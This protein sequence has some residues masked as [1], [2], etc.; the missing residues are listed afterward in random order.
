M[1]D[2]KI[3]NN[4]TTFNLRLIFW[5]TNILFFFKIFF[6]IKN[7]SPQSFLYVVSFFQDTFLVITVY[8]I[9]EFF[10]TKFS[11]I[12]KIITIFFYILLTLITL[13]SFLY[14][15]FITDLLNFP[16]NI[17]AIQTENI[18][19]FL[20]YFL[21]FSLIL[22]VIAL[23]ALIVFLSI[24][25]PKNIN[26]KILLVFSILV[27]VVFLITIPRP[28]IN[29][30][31]YSVTDEIKTIF[32]KSYGIKRLQN[33]QTGINNSGNSKNFIKSFDTIPH[34]TISYDKIIVL[35]M[36]SVNYNDFSNTNNYKTTSFYETNKSNCLIFNNYYTTNLDSYTSLLAML[37]SVFIPYQAYTNENQYLFVNERPNLVSFFNSNNFK[38]LF[39]TSYGE[40][41]KRFI[42]NLK[43]WTQ[44]KCLTDFSEKY[45]CVTTNKIETA[46][47]DF[48]VFEDL[49]NF[50][51]S[52]EKVFV[53]QELVYGH[54]TEWLEKKKIGTLDYYSKFFQSIRDTLKN[55]NLL[56]KTLIIVTSDHGPRQN[57][58]L[59]S[60]YKVPLLLYSPNLK[61]RT[62]DNLLSH[63]DFKDILINT[64]TNKE[65]C[66]ANDYI[67]TI[68]NSGELDYGMITKSNNYVFINNR[69]LSVE[70]NVD[71]KTVQQFNSD[72]QYYLNYFKTLN[73]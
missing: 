47:E 17:F 64:L 21:N 10:L 8:L 6:A 45:V 33:N 5:I 22:P 34:L 55:E 68:G 28:S 30:I 9:F 20:S 2:N 59:L 56:E 46:C 1:I 67:Y 31:I 35:V 15:L 25:F 50:V 57:A 40:Q 70:T 32:K 16:I 29:P 13:N 23:I 3:H 61:N 62:Y 69:V 52:N 26:K 48:A 11:K 66:I 39:L 43:E 73:K 65:I 24:K 71:E 44:V 4:Q 14:T 51:K 41:Q 38:T 72:F 18:S 53:Y 42:P 27:L 49:I 12:K 19:F 60:N 37:N 36:E 7:I 58:K 54:T 63:L